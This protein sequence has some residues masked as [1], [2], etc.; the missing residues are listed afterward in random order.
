MFWELLLQAILHCLE[1]SFFS[2]WLEDASA[3]ELLQSIHCKPRAK[4]SQEGDDMR[5]LDALFREVGQ[6]IGIA[7][8][9][10]GQIGAPYVR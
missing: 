1:V 2:L 8:I 9:R 10:T 6:G 3:I 4:C 7:A 5:S